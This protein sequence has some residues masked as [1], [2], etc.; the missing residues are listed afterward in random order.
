MPYGD[1]TFGAMTQPLPVNPGGNVEEYRMGWLE[2]LQN[3]AVRSGLLQFG[4]QAMQPVPVQQ[5]GPG[6]MGQAIGAGVGAFNRNI[7]DQNRVAQGNQENA[8]KA[9]EL[10]L[11]GEAIDVQRE[12]NRNQYDVGMAGI[13]GRNRNALL[14]SQ[15]RLIA[16]QISAA[17]RADIATQGAMAE[18]ASNEAL[19]GRSITEESAKDR[20]AIINVGKSP[21]LP[22]TGTEG[23]TPPSS[24]PGAGAGGIPSFASEALAD[25]AGAAKQI[26]PGQT[27][28]VDGVRGKWYP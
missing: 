21:A 18:W 8:F 17:T 2:A 15:N 24:V 25:E 13:E 11:R 16:A 20:L 3:P 14:V 5:T 4:L 9:E 23:A 12:G 6:A 22:V 7:E 28:V 27:I 26:Q 1:A 10:G 19:Y